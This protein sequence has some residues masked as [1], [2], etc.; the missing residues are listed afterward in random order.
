VTPALLCDEVDRR[1]ELNRLPQIRKWFHERRGNHRRS[2]PRIHH[3]TSTTYSIATSSGQ[4]LLDAGGR[5]HI[6]DF[7]LAKLLAATA[8]VP[9]RRP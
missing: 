1:R 2:R 8:A 3:A 4:Y 6:T 9:S 5:P 7:G